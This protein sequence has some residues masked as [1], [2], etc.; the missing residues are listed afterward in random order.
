M[1]KK[2]SLGIAALACAAATTASAQSLGSILS[3]IFGTQTPPAVVAGSGQG[4]VYTDSYGR[5]FQYDAYGRQVYLNGAVQPGAV[6]ID[7]YGR[8]YQYDQYGRIVYMNNGA[9]PY[10]AAP[11]APAAP[12]G[13]LISRFYL[14][15]GSLQPGSEAVFVL[16]GRAGGSAYVDMP[17]GVRVP[18]TEV[19]PGVYQGRYLVQWNDNAAAMAQV[20]GALNVGNATTTTQLENRASTAQAFPGLRWPR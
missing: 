15:Q 18:L 6:Y 17:S 2:A 20:F 13:H 11:A 14:A 5:Q 7:S 3:G 8:Q 10:S 12:G 19:Q 16:M 4:P 1:N 9:V